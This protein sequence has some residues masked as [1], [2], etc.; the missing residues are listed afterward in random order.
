MTLISPEIAEL[1]HVRPA[2]AYLVVLAD[3]PETGIEKTA[4]GLFIDVRSSAGGVALPDTVEN[5]PIEGRVV[6]VGPGVSF[7]L[8]YWL[9]ERLADVA[10]ANA[11]FDPEVSTTDMARMFADAAAEPRPLQV[12]V[13][14]RILWTPWAAFSITLEGVAYHVIT[15]DDVVGTITG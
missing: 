10:S 7:E 11:Y 3:V 13:G 9:A 14:D 15:E 2:G 5:E 12:K 8:P 6:A 4:S 1:I